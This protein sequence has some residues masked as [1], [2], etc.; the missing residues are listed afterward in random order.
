MLRSR[1]DGLGRWRLAGMLL[2]LV[3]ALAL[4]PAGAVAQ[5]EIDT[6]PTVTN[7]RADPSSLPADGGLVTV[8]ADANDDGGGIQ[9]V[10]AEI[11][12]PFG[13]PEI[14]YMGF[15][16]VGQTYSGSLTIPANFT[17]SPV[18]Y[19]ITVQAIDING[20]STWETG[21]GITVDAATP[22]D[23]PPVAVDPVVQ[24][25]SLPSGGGSSTIRVNA[26][27][28][29][30]VAAVSATITRPDG[31]TTEVPLEGIGSYQYEG[32]FAAPANTGT[33]AAQYA[34]T[35]TAYDD[36]G[37]STSVDAGVL[38]VA[39]APPPP[40]SAK[41]TVSPGHLSFPTI[42][43]GDK[44]RETF[45]VRNA[46]G[47]SAGTVRGVIAASGAGFALVGGGSQGIAFTLRPGESKAIKVEFRPT[48]V[49]RYA[50][51]VAVRRSDNAQPGLAVRLSGQALPKKHK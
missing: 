5:Q 12:G 13:G 6:P 16:G 26:N 4:S 34:I 25:R 8:F 17:E 1:M 2:A 50:A 37:Q 22:F 38:T 29:R 3:A 45:V 11:Q 40:N 7:V 31:S 24:P 23:E 51:T 10:Q 48:T 9:Q 14:V 46:G 39:A 21:G 18:N 27:D 49:G 44:V 47:R 30:S 42:R 33:T 32:T 20:N 41:L 36:I 19:T 28:D 43:V 35:V 15:T